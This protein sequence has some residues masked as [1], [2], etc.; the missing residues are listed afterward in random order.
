MEEVDSIVLQS[1][2]PLGCINDT[3]VCLDNSSE[4]QIK[5]NCKFSEKKHIGRSAILLNLRKA[6]NKIAHVGM[7]SKNLKQSS[8]FHICNL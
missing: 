8:Q 3:L 6:Y 7:C 4:L 1:I 5:Y 2:D